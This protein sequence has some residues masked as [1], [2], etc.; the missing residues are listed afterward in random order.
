MAAQDY[1]D[2]NRTQY[3]LPR[4]DAGEVYL[5]TGYVSEQ[6]ADSAGAFMNNPTV[7]ITLEAAFKCFG[8]T[9]EFGR[10]HPEAMTFH[11]YYNNALQEDY[12]VTGLEQISVIAMSSQSSTGWC[13][14][15][16]R[17]TR[18]TELWWIIYPSA[19]VRIM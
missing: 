5:N 11:A 19:R 9:L 8:L 12:S 16:P 15:L 7:V 2:T 18:I 17:D 14:S 10:N 3:F 4:N 6:M 13:W 1:S